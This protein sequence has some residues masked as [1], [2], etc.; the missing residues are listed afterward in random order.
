MVETVFFRTVWHHQQ[1]AGNIN[2]SVETAVSASLRPGGVMGRKTVTM[3]WMRTNV[4]MFI[5]RCSLFC[6]RQA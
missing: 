3:A 4:S 5:F 6:S 2:G 1:S